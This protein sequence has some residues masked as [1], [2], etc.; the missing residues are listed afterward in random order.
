MKFA[1]IG[2][3]S[4]GSLI[5]AKLS[6]SGEEVAL[7]GRDPHISKIRKDGL[8]VEFPEEKKSIK[9]MSAFT[10][11]IDLKKSQFNPQL[12]VFT[13]KSYD[14]KQSCEELSEVFGNFS[15]DYILLTFQNGIGNEETISSFFG[16]GK[17]F[18]GALTI[19]VSLLEPGRVR[20]NTLKGGVGL[21]PVE[22]KKKTKEKVNELRK[23]FKKAK[24]NTMIFENYRELKWS[25]LLL[26]IIANASSA[27][28]DLSP[29]EIAK[30]KELFLQEQ[31]AF[32]EACKVTSKLGLKT[33]NLPD[34]NVNLLK[35]IINLP[36]LLSQ[37]ILKNRIGE[38]RG[39]K[40]PSLWQDFKKSK[41]YSEVEVLNGA[42][43]KY[44]QRLQ[45]N[46]PANDFFYHTLKNIIDGKLN[47]ENFKNRNF[48]R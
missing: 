27:I 4:I 40:M 29:L 31:M 11:L 16:E 37:M 5:G 35:F 3:G 17:T 36:Q 24:F 46:T 14:T 45:I 32:K 2:A 43:V 15:N 8:I 26:N 19:S 42:V 44:G 33:V 30:D 12:F 25:K 18:S 23:I 22:I 34:Y 9:N 28:Y 10:N 48:N 21:A 38:S 47:H 7:V 13:M 6:L 1:I 20:Q 39:E 41:K